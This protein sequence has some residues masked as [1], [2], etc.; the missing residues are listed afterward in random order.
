MYRIELAK[1]SDV[2][3]IDETLKVQVFANKENA[4]RTLFIR[5]E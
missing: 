2:L 5:F 3:S 1:R 4:C